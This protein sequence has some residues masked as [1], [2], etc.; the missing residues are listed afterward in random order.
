[1]SGSNPVNVV[2][3]APKRNSPAGL[4]IAAAA[5]KSRASR[6]KYSCAIEDRHRN[7]CRSY[8][9]AR[10]GDEAA[11]DL[12]LECAH[13]FG[14]ARGC[15]IEPA[16]RL[17]DRAIVDYADE[18]FERACVHSK[19]I[20]SFEGTIVDIFV[21]LNS[22]EDIAIRGPAAWNA[23]G[24]QSSAVDNLRHEDSQQVNGTL[25]RAATWEGPTMKHPRRKFLHLLVGA[26]A[27]PALTRIAS[28]QAYPVRPIRLVIPFPPGG[29]FDATGRPWADKVKPHL[30]TIVVENIGGAGSSL[31]TAA[32]ARAQP[33]GYT[34]L[35]GGNAGLVT[36]PIAS[37]KSLY[38]PVKDFEPI[39]VIGYNPTLIEVHPSQP[40]HS[41]KELVDFAK[42][43]PGKLSYGTS[44]VG[45]PNHLVGELF[46]SLTGTEIAHVPYRGSGPA[47]TD[48]ISGHIPMVVQSVTGQIIEL[49]NTGKLR[50]LVT[51]SDRPL[52]AAPSIPTVHQAGFPGLASQNFI[53]LFAPKGTPRATVERVAQA[54]RSAMADRDLQHLFISSGFEPDLESTPEKARYVLDQEIAKWAPVIKGIG[55]TLD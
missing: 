40:I 29:V 15:E 2:C 3:T 27:L 25:G 41:L 36:N 21:R 55:L 31:G 52:S 4:S 24:G 14:H 32:V 23:V 12:G 22:R 1:M 45:S 42:A 47:L 34:I 33:D 19:P 43:N 28:A 20:I 17:G 51:T 53:G 44:G 16:R 46:K 38:N 9:S 30:G 35:L 13:P 5:L 39:A 10:T 49:H 26:A 7:F 54:T 48:L 18:A 50:I 11:A 8:G 6:R 37:A